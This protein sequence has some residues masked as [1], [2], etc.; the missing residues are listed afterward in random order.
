[1]SKTGINIAVFISGRG[2]N[3]KAIIKGCREKK[4]KGRIKLV[5]SNRQSAGGIEISK[6]Y[7]I[8]VFV[9]EK[10]K[11]PH[12]RYERISDLLIAA[13]I[14]I[15]ALAGYLE[16][17]PPALIEQFKNRIINVHPAPLPDFGGKGMYGIKV[18]QKVLESNIK[19]TGPTV[20]LVD[21][22]Y[23][24]GKVLEHFPVEI[25]PDDTPQKLADRVIMKEHELYVAVLS[26]ISVGKITLM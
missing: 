22:K 8:P 6:K 10:K 12:Q 23:D 2:S 17:I 21:Q 11:F 1:V 4:I 9:F 13:D 7:G 15:I 18:H 24:H 5:I 3:L 19:Y 25:F 16:L 20:H 14:D 26:K